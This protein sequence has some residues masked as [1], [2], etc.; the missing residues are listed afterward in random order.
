MKTLSDNI[1][2]DIKFTYPHGGSPGLVKG[3]L[4]FASRVKE[5]IKELEQFIKERTIDLAD[6]HNSFLIKIKEIFGDKL[7]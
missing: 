3:D 2:M 1:L 5:S 6:E 7:I 4:I